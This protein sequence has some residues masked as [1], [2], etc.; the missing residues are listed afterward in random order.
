VLPPFA[1]R[2][3][4]LV[5]GAKAALVLAFAWRYGWQR[6]ELYYLVAGRHLQGG[7]VEFPPVTALLSAFGRIVF[8][9]TLIGFRLLAVL[10]GTAT[11]V[12]AALVARELRGGRTAQALAAG[13][14]AFSPLLIATNGLFQPVSFDQTATMV[15][16]WLA[17]RVALGRANWVWLGVAIGVGL[18]TKYTLGVVLVVLLAA[19]LVWRRDAL[20]LSGLALAAGI[21]VLLVVPN[22]I[23]EARHDW[24][25]VHWFVNPPGSATDESRPEYVV[26]SLLLTGLLTVPVAV[27]GVV[28]LVRDRALRPLG[29]TVVGVVV[30]YLVLGGKSYY[31]LPVAMF[32]LAAG[33]EPLE[34]WATG[35]RL[36]VFLAAYAI[37]LL[38]LLPIGV[39]VLPQGTAIDAGLM[40][41]RTD[42]ADELGW[43]ELARNVER[44]A[45]GA[46]VILA[47]NYGEAGAL[48]LYGRGLPPV[49]TGHVTF[50]YWR[51][52]VQGRSAVIVGLEPTDV[53][54]CAGYRVVARIRMPFANEERG[55]PIARCTLTAP[56]ATVWPRVVA[57]YD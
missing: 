42:Y 31:A 19:F 34:R 15:V 44:H 21:A 36:R 40:D 45:A 37:F 11:A 18:E 49:A 54:W 5:C 32:A 20:E 6:D 51:P 39:P 46:D 53:P 25:S 3:V 55:R 10:A 50:R 17:L 38:V 52:D 14:V 12:V 35:R 41:A 24:V 7:Y 57:L 23:W 33:A 13:L 2:P 43:P 28:R 27:A 26:N 30:A 56:L 48:E 4:A 22:L 1:V 16:L 47:E 29:W 8:G 9:E